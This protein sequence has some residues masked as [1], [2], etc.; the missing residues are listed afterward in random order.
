MPGVKSPKPAIKPCVFN[1][2][3]DAV[4]DKFTS[5]S[6]AAEPTIDNKSGPDPPKRVTPIGT[7]SLSVPLKI[8]STPREL[9]AVSDSST[10]I[11]ST[12]T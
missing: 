2:E 12:K 5:V 1:N 9:A 8:V 7:L 10:I 4:V 11:A 3:A 6:S